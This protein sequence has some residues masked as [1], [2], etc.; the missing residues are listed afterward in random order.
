MK[1][2]DLITKVVS[3]L[4]FG[5]LLAYLGVY[6]FRSATNDVRTAPAVFISLTESSD[7]AGIIVREEALVSSSDKY[8][9]VSAKNGSLLAA[10]DIIAV[11]YN[12]EEALQRAS[13]I[14]ELEL[15]KQYISS[16]LS[17]RSSS[18]NLTERDNSV[19]SAVT[20][21]AAAAARGESDRL[22]SA[23]MS[24]G[25]LVMENTEVNAT[26][27]DLTAITQ[28][29]YQLR[30]TAI[31]DT[32]AITAPK[33]G[34]FSTAPDGYE[35]ITP[36]SIKDIDSEGLRTLAVEP[37]ELA[38]DVRGKLVSP[39]EWYFA[40]VISKKDADK[41]TAGKS[42]L[43]DFGR[44]YSE[45]LTATVVSISPAKQG[46]C[47]VT[48]RCTQATSEMLSVRRVAAEI[49]FETHE[50]IRV[51]KEAVYSDENG[52]YVYTLTGL[53]AEK[54]YISIAWETE[55]YYLADPVKDAAAL[56]VG[57]E[58]LLTSKELYDGKVMN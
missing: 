54:K 38:S 32:A 6:I 56:R 55:D 57:N 28:E 16:V 21:L 36:A 53:Q 50:G 49:I 17:E 47:A 7:A 44:Y 33:S 58:I 19:K 34:L 24:L 9:S 12:N 37:H 23:V 3:L 40:S 13:K 20:E 48:F 22:S 39:Y 51:P 35:F 2:T 18:D 31:N 11:A 1:R 41:L 25:S 10:G 46:E 42:A 45:P 15:K 14:R 29:L 27:S 30:Q 52:S 43:L 4:M 26:E 5:A 8:L